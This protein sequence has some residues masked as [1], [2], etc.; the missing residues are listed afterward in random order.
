MIRF[1]LAYALCWAG[2]ILSGTAGAMA[3]VAAALLFLSLAREG[4]R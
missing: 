4:D 2:V 1:C 3:L